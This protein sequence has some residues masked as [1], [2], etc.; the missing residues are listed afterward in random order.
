MIE[1]ILVLCQTRT[2]SLR[3]VEILRQ[4]I[5][6]A[7]TVSSTPQHHPLPPPHVSLASP[8]FTLLTYWIRSALEEGRLSLVDIKTLTQEWPKSVSNLSPAILRK[9]KTE[10]YFDQENYKRDAVIDQDFEIIDESDNPYGYIRYI[11]ECSSDEMTILLPNAVSDS[12]DSDTSTIHNSTE[13]LR[14]KKL[15]FVAYDDFKT[16]SLTDSKQS[17]DSERQLSCPPVL[18]NSQESL[19]FIDKTP[20]KES[21]FLPYCPPIQVDYED[22]D[23]IN[24]HEW[25]TILVTDQALKNHKSELV[26][27][28]VENE[29][30]RPIASP[31]IPLSTNYVSSQNLY[32]ETKPEESKHL[33]TNV[34]IDEPNV[35][36]EFQAS[37]PEFWSDAKYEIDKVCKVDRIDRTHEPDKDIDKIDS[38]D[39]TDEL[40]RRGRIESSIENE[41]IYESLPRKYCVEIK[42]RISPPKTKTPDLLKNLGG[43][44]PKLK[45]I[46]CKPYI[47]FN[48][49]ISSEEEY[50]PLHGDLE[51]SEHEIPMSSLSKDDTT[52]ESLNEHIEPS[53]KNGMYAHWFMKASIEEEEGTLI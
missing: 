53:F 26:I 44:K 31:V 45:E 42:A 19:F 5:K 32:I 23:H 35:H 22:F 48:K 9:Y 21:L 6:C 38:M 10:F 39:K 14:T 11:S 2:E 43:A 4:Q 30:D 47:C 17:L 15:P 3:W 25:A 29:F 40:H 12:E 1:R 16:C 51:D 20:S 37:K 41:N 24:E 18:K 7:R 28:P 52:E 49:T 34:K 46:K 27:L 33:P 36:F 50:H 13:E 8:P